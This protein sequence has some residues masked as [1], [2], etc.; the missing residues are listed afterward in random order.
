MADKIRVVVLYGGRSGEHEVSLKSAASVFRHLDRT[1]F[2]VIPVSIDKT[3]RWQ[4]NDLQTLDQSHATALPILPDA[5]EMRLARGPDERGALMPITQGAAN[6]IEIDV[7]FPV[8]HGPLCEDGT[9]QGLLELADVAYVGSGVLASAVS[10][11]KDVAKRLAEFAGIPVAPYRVLTRKALVQDRI[12][13]LAKAVEGLNLPVFVKP[14]N[15]GSSVGIHKVKTQDALETALD[16]AFRYDVKVLVEQGI[17]AREI[18][19]A[20][21][22]G[23]T[24]FA[25][26]ASELNPNAH[27]EFYSYEAKYL[28]PDGARVDLPARLDAA[29]MERVRSL[30]TEVFA[31]LECGGF[32]RVDFFLDRQTGEFY[33][34]EINTL[35]GFT[36]ISMYP[37]MM[38]ASGVPYGE[39]LTRLVDLALDRHRQRQSLE[40][41][42]A[43]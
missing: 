1:R 36:S 15:M 38:E 26:V 12:S 24:L 8:I 14:C 40:R 23:E 32:A 34:N 33:F 13:S 18:E 27:H 19:V 9:V 17:D 25:S 37:K 39:L 28:D 16:D 11:D 5:P 29:Q 3:G 20:V 22:E 10:M 43:S 30:A 6:P 31:A 2:E 7:V 21:L 4:W 42:Y 35:P 41:G